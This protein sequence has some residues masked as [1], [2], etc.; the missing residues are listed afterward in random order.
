MREY[1]HNVEASTAKE[2]QVAAL[3]QELEGTSRIIYYWIAEINGRNVE[4]ESGREKEKFK[5]EEVDSGEGE[6]ELVY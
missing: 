3:K 2:E 5:K 1:E 4:M 6:R